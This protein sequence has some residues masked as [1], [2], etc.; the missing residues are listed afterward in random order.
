MAEKSL[1]YYSISER[2]YEDYR[3]TVVAHEKK[4][5]FEEF[6]ILLNKVIEELKVEK[7]KDPSIV[8][9][10]KEFLEREEVV[11]KLTTKY[12]FIKIESFY[13]A[14]IDPHEDSSKFKFYK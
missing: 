3:E 14:H 5:T 13:R 6:K 7:K 1:N 4:F 12:G 2:E 8:E 9:E 11:E 10:D